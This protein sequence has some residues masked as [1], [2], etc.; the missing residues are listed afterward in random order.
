MLI[1][2][3][4]LPKDSSMELWTTDASAYSQVFRPGPDD[5]G[6]ARFIKPPFDS[7]YRHKAV[8]VEIDQA[9]FEVYLTTLPEDL[10]ERFHKFPDRADLL[11]S[12]P[13]DPLFWNFCYSM[14]GNNYVKCYNGIMGNYLFRVLHF[15]VRDKFASNLYNTV[16]ELDKHFAFAQNTDGGKAL[17]MQLKLRFG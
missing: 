3:T 17:L 7:N 1:T 16:Y 2:H 11:L 9:K 15:T 4:D 13:N 8:G 12:D 10:N 14:G 6:F 5:K